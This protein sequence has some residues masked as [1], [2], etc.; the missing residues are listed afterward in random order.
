MGIDNKNDFPKY[1]YRWN[2][3]AI[4]KTLLEIEWIVGNFSLIRFLEWNNNAR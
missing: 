4:L 1:L 2:V 3:K